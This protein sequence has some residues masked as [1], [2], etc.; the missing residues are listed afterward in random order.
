MGLPASNPYVPLNYSLI[1]Q[2]QLFEINNS[3]ID[4]SIKIFEEQLVLKS[5]WPFIG[6]DFPN[7]DWIAMDQPQTN[8]S[9]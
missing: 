6:D 8:V 4:E 5:Q 3:D 1:D 9:V 7:I 2:R